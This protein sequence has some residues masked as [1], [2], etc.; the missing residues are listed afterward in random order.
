MHKTTIHSWLYLLVSI[1]ILAVTIAPPASAR[2][3]KVTVC[4][5]PPGNPGNPQTIEVKQKAVSAHLAH[6]DTLGECAGGTCGNDILEEGEQCEPRLFGQQDEPDCDEQF[7]EGWLG[8][9]GCTSTCLFDISFCSLCGNGIREGIEECDDG[10][11]DD[12]DACLST[13]TFEPPP[14]PPP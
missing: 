5:Q 1:A 14:P 11:T 3:D 9:L 2:A 13:C 6:G 12:G 4:H 8:E 10:N 7:G